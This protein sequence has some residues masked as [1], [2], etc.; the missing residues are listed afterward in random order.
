MRS[1]DG[2]VMLTYA[3]VCCRML[4]Y[5]EVCRRMLM[6]ADECALSGDGTVRIPPP[7]LLFAQVYMCICVSGCVRWFGCDSAANP[8]C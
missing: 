5:A 6:N 2:N 1:N 4:T 8:A 3:N 7:S